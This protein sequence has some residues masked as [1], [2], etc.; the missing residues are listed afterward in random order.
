VA[1]RGPLVPK[2]P[3]RGRRR[4]NVPGVKVRSALAA[5]AGYLED[6]LPRPAVDDV[7]NEGLRTQR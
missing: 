3:A 5:C 6:Q 2:P 7:D 4:K 1:P